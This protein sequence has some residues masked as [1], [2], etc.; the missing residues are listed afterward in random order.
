MKIH[1][2]DPGHGIACGT[3]YSAW[4]GKAGEGITCNPQACTCHE[5]TNTYVYQQALIKELDVIE[6]RMPRHLHRYLIQELS[7]LL[8]LVDE[9]PRSMALSEILQR[10]DGAEK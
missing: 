10:I 3:S 1:Y 4:R 8:S 6:I 7:I 9:Y 5:C 2:E